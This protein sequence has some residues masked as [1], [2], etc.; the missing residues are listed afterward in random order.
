MKERDL[1]KMLKNSNAD[2]LVIWTTPLNLPIVQP[3]RKVKYKNVKT[4]LQSVQINDPYA[5]HNVHVMRQ[6]S[7]FPPNFIHSLDSTHML[8][9]ALSC[10][11]VRD[12]FVH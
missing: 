6:K 2:T 5:K 12:C 4:A 1:L 9:T 11:G 3:Y 10:E 7:A 8:M